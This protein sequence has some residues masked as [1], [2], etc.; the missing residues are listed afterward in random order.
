MA[1]I[2]LKVDWRSERVDNKDL[3]DGKFHGIYIF[4][5]DE[6]E[7]DPELGYGVY[8]VLEYLWYE[9]PKERNVAYDLLD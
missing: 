6:D 1:N 3:N 9:T 8:E 4:D 7:Y 2:K 5:C